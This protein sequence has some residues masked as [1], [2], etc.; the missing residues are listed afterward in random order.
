MM[1]IRP[2][3]ALVGLML[4]LQFY[5]HSR[6]NPLTSKRP[7]PEPAFRQEGLG[8]KGGVRQR[9]FQ[10][11]RFRGLAPPVGSENLIR[12]PIVNVQRLAAEPL[13]PG[14]PPLALSNAAGQIICH[15]QDTTRGIC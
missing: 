4:K 2:A 5:R 9:L 1:V 12:L 7:S 15:A 8:K 10:K 13:R 11:G 14:L 3:P 6:R